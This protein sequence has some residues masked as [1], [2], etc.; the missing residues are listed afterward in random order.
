MEIPIPSSPPM[1]ECTSNDDL[2]ALINDIDFGE[3]RSACDGDESH[4]AQAT[5]T[6]QPVDAVAAHPMHESALETHNS[7]TLRVQRTRERNMQAQAKY[8]Q[9]LKE[10]CISL[11][12]QVQE[13]KAR[14]DTSFS[15][16]ATLQ[17]ANDEHKARISASSDA[18]V[19]LAAQAAG[20]AQHPVNPSSHSPTPSAP[21]HCNPASA[22]ASTA[23]PSQSSS[24]AMIG[25]QEH[26]GLRTDTDAAPAP[27]HSFKHSAG[28]AFERLYRAAS[29]LE[30]QSD[31]IQPGF[32]RFVEEQR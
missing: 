24:I 25:T 1:H 10:Q 11:E 15:N 32:W 31:S 26:R 23:A 17:H 16:L 18:L 12:R 27:I 14:L 7:E 29:C 5:S 13:L 21:G 8:R 22:E 6:Q 28:V 2:A 3:E 4:D 9:K 19:V 20:P 30:T